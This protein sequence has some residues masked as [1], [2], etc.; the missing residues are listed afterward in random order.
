M[1]AKQKNINPFFYTK[2]LE[3]I[4]LHPSYLCCAFLGICVTHKLLV[5]VRNASTQAVYSSVGRELLEIPT[6]KVS[7]LSIHHQGVEI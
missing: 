3:N 4:F 6:G 5:L 1:Q 7:L 2:D